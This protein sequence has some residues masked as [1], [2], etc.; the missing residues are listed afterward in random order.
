MWI[1]GKISLNHLKNLYFFLFELV[2]FPFIS[3]IN[4]GGAFI[5]FKKVY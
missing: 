4:V 3:F 1:L 2:I 5:I